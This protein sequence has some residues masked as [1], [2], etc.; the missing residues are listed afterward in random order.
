M[1]S[2][3][4]NSD[5]FSQ[6]RWVAL[7]L[8]VVVLLPTVCLLW[9]M[10]RANE[11]ERLAVRQKLVD[12]YQNKV[13]GLRESMELN[14]LSQP[15]ILAKQIHRQPSAF[16]EYSATTA[17][18]GA[19]GILIYA[20][21]GSLAYP[22]IIDTMT[23]RADLP[24]EFERA[25]QL[26]FFEKMY[27]RA[28]NSYKTI[29][30][31]T[32][33]DAVRIKAIIGMVRCLN[34]I[35]E[36]E[37]AVQLC[38]QILDSYNA[39]Y[40]GS[41]TATQICHARLMLVSLYKNQEIKDEIYK[42]ELAKLLSG[43]YNQS[44]ASDTRIFLLRKAIE[45]AKSDGQYT[46]LKDL[47]SHAQMLVAAE[48]CSRVAATR[49]PTTL[50]LDGWP[51]KTIRRLDL[52]EPIYGVCY[53]IEDKTILIL[54][55][56]QRLW[57]YLQNYVNDM[58]DA[59]IICRVLDNTST[60][61]VGPSKL[62]GKPFITDSISRKYLS[63][64]QV[65]LY[66]KNA[67]I[68][69]EAARQQNMLY[70]WIALLVIALLVGAA[71]LAGR[72]VS[73]QIRLNK[74]KNDFIATVSHELKT[75]L[76]SMRLLVDTLLEGRYHDQQQVREYLQLTATEN[77]R[78]TRLID[79]FLTFSR[80]EHGK[81]A[82]DIIPTSPTDIAQ[83]AVQAVKTHYQN[84]HCQLDLQIEDSLPEVAAD[85]DAMVTVLVNL[86]DNACKYTYDDNKLV[87]L[88]V[89]CQDDSVRFAVKDNGIGL[90]KRACRKIFDRFYQCDRTLSR[91]TL[92][93]GLGLSIVKFIL[94]AH[95]AS[96]TVKSQISK[97]S[98]FIVKLFVTK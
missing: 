84:N 73:K 23:K 1:R 46:Q 6:L 91:R 25:W 95:H 77:Q 57:S 80:M 98:T 66:F 8:S 49:Y 7:L 11:N 65:E 64:W 32:S 35:G 27:Q 92:G 86:L 26:E 85:H 70:T 71:V 13:D 44:V 33:H 18:L 9:F 34:K 43:N 51:A 75:P 63:D 88:K 56:K 40:A 3:K 39:D 96:I 62:V 28:I 50:S 67:D 81:Q 4:A 31:N 55:K 22:I 87:C 45:L 19:D 12:I 94:D 78:L 97:G 68:F 82:F 52:P 89:F 47:L 41:T 76:S 69:G 5:N 58:N 59:S 48:Q 93:C 54:L 42:S 20:K 37:K 2:K 16:F 74:L 24:I 90:S 30:D 72:I 15:E 83:D 21:Q 36:I 10:A 17:G 61:I 14:W 79:N 60:C 38:K 29:A 53:H